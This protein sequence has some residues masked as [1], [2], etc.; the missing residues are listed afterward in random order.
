MTIGRIVAAAAI[1]MG[2]VV[3]MAPAASAASHHV[4]V[5]TDDP[6]PKDGMA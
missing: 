6:D 4:D 3:S 2:T 5:C 1:A